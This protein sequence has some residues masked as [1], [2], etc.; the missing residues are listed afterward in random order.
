MAGVLYVVSTPIGNLKDITIRA[1][2]VLRTV[3][4]ILCEDTRRTK[5]L[6]TNYNISKPLTSFYEQNRFK[7]IPFIIEEL[8]KGNNLAIVSEA[9]TPGIS[10]PGFFLVEKAIEKNIQVIAIPGASAVITAL[11]GSGLPTDGF[12]F[13]GFLPRKKGKIKKTVERFMGLEKTIVFYESP[14]RIK[15]TMEILKEVF[16]GNVKVVI[17][18]EMTKKF[19]EFI[20]G[21]ISDIS[22][23]LP[24][25]ILGE[26][27]VIISEKGI[28]LNK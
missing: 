25:K 14:Y 8:K 11:T 12:I 5:I 19:E 2:E 10:D 18:R 20:R 16:P 6:L 26:I 15:R 24:G 23:K 17:A 7:K 28:D 4:L 27:T 3:D 22:A 13:L 21:D 9:G 1:L